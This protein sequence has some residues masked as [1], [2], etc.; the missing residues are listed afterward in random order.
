MPFKEPTEFEHK[1][2]ALSQL[3]LTE[4]R[5]NGIEN[6]IRDTEERYVKNDRKSQIGVLEKL[7]TI[8]AE[9]NEVQNDLSKKFKV[10]MKDVFQ[11]QEFVNRTL[12][13]RKYFSQ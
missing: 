8:T 11:K 7:K 13:K 12:P 2:N 10:A 6:I 1:R 4:R 9:I 3:R 5:L